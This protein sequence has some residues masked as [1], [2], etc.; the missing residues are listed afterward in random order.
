M[1]PIVQRELISI[2]RTRRALVVQVSLLA[3]LSS[4][5]LLSWPVDAKVD[6]EAAASA[7][8]LRMFGYGLMIGLI[9]LAPAFPAVSIVSERKAGTLELL[10]NSPMSSWSIVTGKLAAA[11]GFVFLLLIT[12]LPP[13]VACFAMGGI[14]LKGQLLPLY[15]VL[16]LLATQYATLGLLVSSYAQSTESALRVTYGLILLMAVITL[17]PNQLLGEM[18][19]SQLVHWILCISPIPAMTQLLGQGAIWGR[20]T[21]IA[22]DLANQYAILA[23]ASSVIF[24]IWT[25]ARLN[26]RLLD[27][28]RAT[29]KV[30][31]ERSSITRAYRRVMFLW[32]FDPNRRS[33][34]I[35]S[36]TNPIMA[37]EFRTRRFGRSHWMMRLIFGCVIISLVLTLAA[38]SGTET[39]GIG[40]LGGIMVVLQGALIIVVTPSLA[41]GLISAEREGGGWQLLQMTPLSSTRI[42]T[43]KLLSVLWTLGLVLL[44]T[45]PGYVVLII[46]DRGQTGTVV[47]V[48]LTLVLTAVFAIFLSALVS[49]VFK[50]TAAATAT[51][52]GV[53]VIWCIGTMLI[54]LGRDT[55]FP[56]K[57][58][59]AVLR[60]NPLAAALSLIRAPD[61]VQYDLV[62][63]TWWIISSVT[64]A[65]LCLL[66]FQTWRLTRPD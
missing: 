3:V 23:G 7:K 21:I 56:H 4:L 42:V 39:R 44:A 14:D 25:A 29:V 6:L 18:H 58:V 49:S 20:D 48:L 30:T 28:N 53:L 41:A 60:F 66:I 51:A 10:L 26:L 36:W 5:V 55:M 2:L 8:V 17:G 40:T 13:A 52:Y 15:G 22:A 50:K 1:N 65:C 54:W 64:G 16:A 61:F 19:S 59:E 33:E 32:F 35:G 57:T 47:Q 9:L 24:I 27:R 38:A 43:G 45:V 63:A 34:L 31:D 62:P 12:S 46:I 37:K 11:I